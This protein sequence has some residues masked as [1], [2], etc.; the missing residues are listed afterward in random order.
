MCAIDWLSC[1]LAIF[2]SR[3]LACLNGFVDHINISYSSD[4]TTFVRETF[5]LIIHDNNTNSTSSYVEHSDKNIILTVGSRSL[6]NVT[7]AVT[8][9]IRD[10]VMEHFQNSSK[11]HRISYSAFLKGDLFQPLDSGR[12]LSLQSIVFGIRINNAQIVNLSSP[13]EVYFQADKV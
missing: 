5:V 2:F 7:A 1:L 4:S 3:I 13:I 9:V 8:A 10:S 6:Q 12:G 11:G